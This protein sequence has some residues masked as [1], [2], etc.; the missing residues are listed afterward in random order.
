MALSAGSLNKSQYCPQFSSQGDSNV[1]HPRQHLQRMEVNSFS[2]VVAWHTYVV[3]T[4]YRCA[5]HDFRL[6]LA[7]ERASCGSLFLNPPL[8]RLM[9]SISSAVIEE[10]KTLCDEGLASMAY[11]YFDFRDKDKKNRRNL[12]LSLIIQLSSQ[13]DTYCEILSHLHSVHRDGTETAS[14]D[15]LTKCLKQMLSFPSERPIYLVMDALDECPKNIGL[16]SSREQVLELVKDLVDLR[17][18]NLHICVTSRPESDIRTRLGPLAS[19]RVSLHDQDGQKEDIVKYVTSVVYSDANM[20]RW[21][22]EDRRLVVE[23][24]SEKADGMWV[25]HFPYTS[26]MLIYWQVQMGVL[27]A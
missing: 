22:E 15:V 12:L 27:P 7:Q 21:R 9:I 25:Y 10:I 23:T 17:L 26:Y 19:L 13:S 3:L 2:F 5:P 24:L 4:P 11:F 1:V 18:P 14:D 20:G 16:P 6:Q 8:P